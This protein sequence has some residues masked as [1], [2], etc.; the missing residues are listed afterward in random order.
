[1]TQSEKVAHL[2][3][4]LKAK[5]INQYTTAPP[6]FR[7]LWAFGVDVPP[8]FFIHF[9]PLALLVGLP[10]GAAMA[11]FFWSVTS[12]DSTITATPRRA[13]AVVIAVSNA[14]GIWAGVETKSLPMTIV[15]RTGTVYRFTVCGGLQE[16]FRGLRSCGHSVG[17]ESTY[18]PTL[19]GFFY[20]TGLPDRCKA[21]LLT[22]ADFLS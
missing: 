22:G 5:G 20:L 4:E 17:S 18:C 8:P 13:I 11:V 2:I 14:R 9:F 6:M 10:F 7:A 12:P 3:S 19:L 1:M 21:A 15:L 16:H